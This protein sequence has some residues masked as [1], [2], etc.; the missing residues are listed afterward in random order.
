MAVLAIV[1]ALIISL[2]ALTVSFLTFYFEWHKPFSLVATMRGQILYPPLHPGT[3]FSIIMPIVF[4]NTGARTGSVEAAYIRL[5]NESSSLEYRLEA[6]TTVDTIR[7]IQLVGVI[8][9]PEG[10][11]ALKSLT[12]F[13]HLGKYEA[14]E[15]GVHF[16]F[17]PADAKRYTMFS[18]PGTIILGDYQLELWCLVGG[19][20]G[21][22]AANPVFT[23]RAEQVRE[24]LEGRPSINFYGGIYDTAPGAPL[25]TEVYES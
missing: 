10:A 15:V 5:W 18:D 13:V 24:A 23:L 3:P 9:E 4:R 8:K 19:R 25:G 16:T 20:W 21:C 14:T 12:G 17:P 22:Y 2:S 6:M 1:L 7:A 11:E